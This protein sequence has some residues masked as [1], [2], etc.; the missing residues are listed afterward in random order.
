MEN[1]LRAW[2]IGITVV[3]S[4]LCILLLVAF[5]LKTRSLSQRL[6]K[7]SVIRYGSQESVSNR[8]AAPFTNKHATEGSNPA[9]SEDKIKSPEG[10][11]AISVSSGDSDL[12]GVE[13][14]PEFDYKYEKQE[15]S[16]K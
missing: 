9:Y 11:D 2:L 10:E 6:N 1:V 5:I 4:T 14:N 7:L 15:N 16:T 3:M 13:N 8:R 12:V